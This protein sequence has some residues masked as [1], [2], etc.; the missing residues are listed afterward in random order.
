[1][2][3]LLKQN[4]KKLFHNIDKRRIDYNYSTNDVYI[5]IDESGTLTKND[6][7]FILSCFI[8]DSIDM[9]R[10]QLDKLRKDILSSPYFYAYRDLFLRQGFHA[11]DNHPDIRSRYYALLP[12]LNIRI[13]SLIIKKSSNYF[14]NICQKCASNDEI[15][16]CFVKTL[17]FD[18]I[19]S[20]CMKPIHIIFEEYGDSITR[21][22]TNMQNIVRHISQYISN[23]R[24]HNINVDVEIHKKDDIVLSVIDYTNYILYQILNNDNNTRMMDNFKLIEP[25]IALLY[26]L[27][28][29][30]FYGRRKRINFAEIKQAGRR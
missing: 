30:K 8:S 23:K 5:Y 4:I 24:R 16:A 11:C 13:Y 22:K 20:E 7:Y 25:K 10:E 17:L 3:K 2:W 29:K 21:H 27:H 26:S 18:R 1:M 6:D 28:N 12:K 9:I 15:Y 14:S 19:E